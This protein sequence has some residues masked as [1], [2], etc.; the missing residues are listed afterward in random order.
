MAIHPLAGKPAP[1]EVLVDLDRLRKEYYAWTPDAA[2][3]T[4]RV[5]FG[6]SGH[7]AFA[8]AMEA[9]NLVGREK[10]ATLV[11]RGNPLFAGAR[12]RSSQA[13]RG[14][15]RRSLNMRHSRILVFVALV[16]STVAQGQ[17][18]QSQ[19]PKAKP[20]VGMQTRA[21]EGLEIWQ[22]D[23]NPSGTG[24]ALTRPVLEGDVY[25]FKVWPDRATVR[26]PRSRVKKMARRTQDINGEV[27]YQIDL[28]PSGQMYA[29]ENPTRKETTYVFHTWRENSLMSVRQTDV[30][31]IT[32]VT[33][34]DAFKIH[35][36]QL[37]TK[38]IDNVPMEGGG[39]V[40]VI[41]APPSAA[42]EGAAAPDSARPGNWIYDGVPGVTEAW[43]PPSAV[44][45]SPGDVPKAPEPRPHN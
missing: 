43:A 22:I 3:S 33:G 27:L 13:G 6:T 34:L 7:R 16:L 20:E 37:G 24:F 18:P 32:R 5:R 30:K 44:V 8:T 19:Q 28:L 11:R 45:N 25:V 38:A 23:L 21:E 10:M 39:T 17:Q 26:L 29:R 2:D 9:M 1:K 12:G 14:E 40:S 15:F 35:L 4:Q 31:K 36:Q 41:S 42:A